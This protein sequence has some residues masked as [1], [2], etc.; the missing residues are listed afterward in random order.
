MKKSIIILLSFLSTLAFSNSELDIQR[1]RIAMKSKVGISNRI[2][3]VR[4]IVSKVE[5]QICGSAGNT[6]KAQF[7][8]KRHDRV[9]DNN[10]QVTLKSRFETIKTYGV[11]A[12]VVSQLSDAELKNEIMDNETC[13]E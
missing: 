10:G 13:L 1:V 12:A 8:V 7:Q 2:G 6:Y 4:L 3:D 11:P 9:L 5:E